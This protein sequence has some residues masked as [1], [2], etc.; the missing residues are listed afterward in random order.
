ML[1]EWY[2]NHRAAS[3]EIS[4]E[5]SQKLLG[6]LTRWWKEAG[7]QWGVQSPLRPEVAE[8]VESTRIPITEP[9]TSST[10]GSFSLPIFGSSRSNSCS[11]AKPSAPHRLSPPRKVSALLESSHSTSSNG[12][13][14]DLHTSIKMNSPRDSIPFPES[15]SSSTTLTLPTP[16]SAFKYPDMASLAPYRPRALSNVSNIDMNPTYT[17]RSPR[18]PADEPSPMLGLKLG[19]RDKGLTLPSLGSLGGGNRAR[20]NSWWRDNKHSDRSP[21]GIAAL[22]SAAEERGE[23]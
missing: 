21:L 14:L 17:M 1:T 8:P 4:T 22:I 3:S 20:S 15:A 19:E 2:D 12:L 7:E 6:R 10:S 23:V 18:S 5:D 16:T 9:A 13:G 11:L